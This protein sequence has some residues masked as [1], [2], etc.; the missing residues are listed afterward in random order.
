MTGELY[1][2]A[3]EIREFGNRTKLVVDWTSDSSGHVISDN[4]EA[5]GYLTEIET[6]PGA[7]G[8]KSTNTPTNNYDILITD[9]YGYD[10]AAGKMGANRSSSI[11]QR[12]LA[13]N[14][15]WVDD[16]II[17]SIDNAGGTKQGRLIL[18][19]DRSI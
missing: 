5:A 16:Y 3:V 9:T 12:Q 2:N 18:W 17:V 4:I 11:A 10:I 19:F 14:P 8:D 1:I 15:A 6:I 13:A 7:S